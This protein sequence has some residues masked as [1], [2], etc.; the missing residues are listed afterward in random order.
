MI[1][2]LLDIRIVAFTVLA[3]ILSVS[4]VRSSYDVDEENMTIDSLALSDDYRMMEI[5]SSIS[6]DYDES[7]VLDSTG[8]NTRI[9]E[10]VDSKRKT[11]VMFPLDI[12]VRRVRN[13][14]AERFD[15]IGLGMLV[16]VDLTLPQEVIEAEKRAVERILRFF[17]EDNLYVAFLK[18]DGIISDTQLVSDYVLDNCFNEDLGSGDKHLYSAI[19]T[20]MKEMN[21]GNGVMRDEKNKVLFVMSDGNVWGDGVPLDPDHFNVQKRLEEYIVKSDWEGHFYYANFKPDTQEDILYDST[22][23]SILALCSIAGGLYQESFDWVE[24]C[25]SIERH[26]GLSHSDFLFYLA[27]RDGRAYDGARRK[28]IVQV[29]NDNDSA[30]VVGSVSY[31]EGNVFFPIIVNGVSNR[32]ITFR[33]V[34]LLMA[35]LALCFVILQ[36][37]IPGIRYRI[38]LKR[39]V[40]TYKGPNM[41]ANG[42]EVMDSCYLCKA[43]F[44]DGDTIVTK[45]EHTMHLECWNENG[46]H[47]PE[48]GYRCKNGSHYYNSSK[49]LDMHNAPDFT[50]WLYIAL[51]A[52][53]VGWIV[54]YVFA[55]GLTSVITKLPVVQTYQYA[56]GE[57][58]YNDRIERFY[59]YIA[60]LPAFA[61][62]LGVPLV[63]MLSIIVDNHNTFWRTTLIVALRTLAAFVLGF[64]LFGLNGLFNI[65]I[66][67]WVL[68]EPIEI[69][70]WIIY[71][72]GIT[73]IA[74]FRTSSMIR[75]DRKFIILLLVAVL[76]IDGWSYLL[77]VT[78]GDYRTCIPLLYIIYDTLVV[79]AISGIAPSSNRYVLHTVGCLKT[80]DVAL[81]KW[82]MCNPD[83][84]VTI[85]RSVDCSIQLSWDIKSDIAPIQAEIYM[86]NSNI[87]LKAIE[88]GVII[89]DKDLKPGKSIRLYKY[90]RFTIGSTK[91]TYR[92]QNL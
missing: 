84:I 85:G 87:Y 14:T 41:C 64:V 40:V 69:L 36:I 66:T 80:T 58:S 37:I 54:F 6:A 2:R 72:F 34:Y 15:S 31:Q 82:F 86:K 29:Y 50:K 28:L 55:D 25:S 7:L 39:N 1:D 48:H 78:I 35:I 30:S 79:L 61:V 13:L 8:L 24:C 67:S 70:T 77:Y 26:F 51:L 75:P 17:C 44:Q 83:A 56:P 60:Y 63:L 45:C 11:S 33:G 4:C 91:F 59:T 20:K 47:C 9:F 22:N 38:F 52:S 89:N 81:Y 57:I 12:Q 68:E 16:I 43:P 19:L 49:I 73:F 27:N 21:S 71:T 23:K 3:G 74:T 42:M 18:S 76:A 65:I 32:V 46:Y 10:T 92:E 88:N 5:Y 62:S 53:I 90:S